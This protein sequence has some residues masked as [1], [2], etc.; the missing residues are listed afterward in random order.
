[1][2]FGLV[3][4]VTVASVPKAVFIVAGG[5]VAASVALSFLVRP[6]ERGEQENLEEESRG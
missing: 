4:S 2:V 6:L 1:M 5:V 3:Y